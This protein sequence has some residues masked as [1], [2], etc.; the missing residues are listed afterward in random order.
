MRE[1][2]LSQLLVSILSAYPQTLFLP[3]FPVS[4]D[5]VTPVAA[6]AEALVSSHSKI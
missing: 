2:E 6:N 1:T 4:A 5:I 3:E